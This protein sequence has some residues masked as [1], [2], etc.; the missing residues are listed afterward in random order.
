LDLARGF[1]AAGHGVVVL[2]PAMSRPD[3]VAA[4][5]DRREL[6]VVK[7]SRIWHRLFDW[8]ANHKSPILNR[9]A[10]ALIIP[11]V[12]RLASKLARDAE[13]IIVGHASPLGN[14]AAALKRL[15]PNLRT[16]VM[17]YG[18]EIATFSQGPRMR[19][20]LANALESADAVTCLTSASAGEFMRFVP[21]LKGRVHVIP[22]AVPMDDNKPL[23]SP[24]QLRMVASFEKL[25]GKVSKD[26]TKR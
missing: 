22:P 6:Y 21:A 19:D 25:I 23:Q 15:R 20:M 7:R 5:F 1:S 3:A 8:G 16:I 13:V 17:T 11:V 10:R 9:G 4:E 14:V 26:K 2:C 12:F 24:E 18:D